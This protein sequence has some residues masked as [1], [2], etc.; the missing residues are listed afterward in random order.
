MR[1]DYPDSSYRV[2]QQ[3]CVNFE[4]KD[5]NLPLWYG[6]RHSCYGPWGEGERAL[7]GGCAGQVSLCHNCHRDHHPGGYET[8]PLPPLPE[9]E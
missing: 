6:N 4:S 3:P 7:K 1:S 2:G 9:Q 8:C 5:E